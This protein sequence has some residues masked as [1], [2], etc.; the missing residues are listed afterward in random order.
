MTLFRRVDAAGKLGPW[1]MLAL[2]V[3][4]FP[5]A[6]RA[7]TPLVFLSPVNDQITP[8]GFSIDPD[9][10][11]LF[12][13]GA[14]WQKAM[15]RVNAFEIVNH[16]VFTQDET[17]LRSIFS[18]L[19]EHNI[20]LAVVFGLVP[21]TNGCGRGV[22]GATAGQ[23]N[24]GVAKRLKRLGAD[25]KYIVVDEPLTFGHYSAA[26]DACRYSIDQL[27]EGFRSEAARIRSIYPNTPII[28]EEAESGIG[29][30]EE[31]GLWLDALK[32]ELGEE[33]PISI[34]FDVQWGSSKKPWRQVAPP[35]VD[36][37][38]RHGYHYGVI[39]DG[40]PQDPTA[41]DWIRSAEAHIK[42]WEAVIH[43]APDHIAIKSWH[44]Q[45]ALVLPESSPTTLPYLVNWYCKHF[46]EAISPN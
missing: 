39:Y 43:R 30:P 38:L 25:L 34:R 24:L 10:R 35:L 2:A 12:H 3:A 14:S 29:A 19:H 23:Y 27:A 26:K 42:E 13:P 6:V 46:S 21:S 17:I 15:S 8:A 44:H 1:F 4:F 32:R 7:S 33:A 9:Y 45:P 40:N 11:Q 41:E 36:A 18:F 28:E 16:Y 20:A 37:V 5:T 31:L 22:E